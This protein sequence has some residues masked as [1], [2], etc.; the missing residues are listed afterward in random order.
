MKCKQKA[1]Y[2]LKSI[3]RDNWENIIEKNVERKNIKMRT[4]K[5]Q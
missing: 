2:Y 1:K 4:V 3:C 5:Q